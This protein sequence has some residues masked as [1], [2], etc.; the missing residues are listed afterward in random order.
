MRLLVAHK[1]AVSF[2]NDGVRAAVGHN[3][4]LLTPGVKLREELVGLR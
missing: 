2:D 1:R 4:A 3:C